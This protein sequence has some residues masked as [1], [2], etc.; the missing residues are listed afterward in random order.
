MKAESL[1]LKKVFQGE[2]RYE[3]PL[4]QRP[5]VWRHDEKDPANDRLG[6]FWEDIEQ[7]IGRL[8]EHNKLIEQAED[9]HKVLPMAGH[10]FGAVVVDR[11][12]KDS[13]HVT[14]HEVIDGQ[15]RLTTAQLFVSA[16]A[17]LCETE[18]RPQHASRLR[19][20]VAQQEDLELVGPDALKLRPT[21]H[22]RT[23]FTTVMERVG[24]AAADSPITKA[25]VYF[26]SRLAEWAAALPAGEATVY[27]DALRDTISE[28][29]LIVLIELEGGD[30]AQAIFES[31]NAQ[32][33]RLLAIDL[34]KNQAFRRARQAGLDLDTL[35]TDVWSARFAADGWW[36]KPV[37]Q[38]R[39]NRPRAELFLMHWLAEQTLKEISA[40]GLFVE[41]TRL[42]GDVTK[43]GVESFIDAFVSDAGTYRSFSEAPAKTRERLFFDRRK[44][45]DT[46][47]VFPVTLRLWRARHDGVIDDERLRVGLRALESFLVRRLV[48]RLTTKNYNRM[49]LDVLIAMSEATTDPVAAL[50]GQL[51]SYG[52]DTPSGWW[53]NDPAFV[54]ALVQQPLYDQMTQARLRMLLEA[55]EARL[56]TN[57]TEEFSFDSPLT[58][59]HVIPQT[60]PTYWPPHDPTDE[61]AVAARK[62]AIHRLGNLTLVTGKLNPSMGNDP[63]EKKRNALKEHSALRL[64]SRLVNTHPNTFHEEAVTTRGSQLAVLL[65]TEWPGPDSP[66]WSI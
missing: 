44:T 53:P 11:P 34:V 9:A 13:S 27:F 48:L 61:D 20:L 37:K 45:L 28:H 63:W 14:T 41:F 8:I 66:E 15:Q 18:R 16:A 60:W 42:F 39:Y 64:N 23:A 26:E 25:N 51:R 17:R 50:I 32:G 65:V 10:F 55:A 31:L 40:T 35:D 43:Q 12:E 6:P 3:V 52:E 4:Y 62:A 2:T 30:N 36:R 56:H 46:S 58:I 57:K 38:G 5:Y 7:T 33:E 54:S 1:T 47:V 21:R 29:L 49:M 59:E 19:R 24:V 22:D